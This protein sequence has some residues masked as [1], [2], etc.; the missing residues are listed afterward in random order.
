M[1]DFWMVFV[2][3]FVAVD[4]MGILPIYMGLVE[5]VSPAERRRVVKHSFFTALSVAVGFIFLGKGIFRF[6]GISVSDFMVAG[7]ALLF[8]IATLDLTSGTKFA[9]RVDTLGAVPLG[10]PLIVGPAVLTTS[11]MLVDVHGLAATLAAVLLN[12]V[13]AVGILLTAEFWNRL[14]GSTGSQALSKVASLILA[15]IAVM[16]IRRG[17]LGIFPGWGGGV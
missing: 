17:L 13:L 14:L 15:A 8:I 5:G 3:L 11:L 1:R 16:M 2:P 10:V 12:L 7:G 4:A 6:L 9:R